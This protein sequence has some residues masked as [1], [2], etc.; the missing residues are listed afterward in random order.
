MYSGFILIE[1][2]KTRRHGNDC[3]EGKI[4]L[5]KHSLEAGGMP[6]QAGSHQ[7]EPGSVRS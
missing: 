7:E 4:F 5:L 2:G 1:Y 6:H 3:H